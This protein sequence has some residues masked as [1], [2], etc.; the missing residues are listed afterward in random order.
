MSQQE[1]EPIYCTVQDVGD[2]MNIS[3][4]DTTR[5]SETQVKKKINEIQDSINRKT[6]TAF[7][8]VVA[9][10]EEHDLE[11]SYQQGWGYNISLLHRNVKPFDYSKGD[12]IQY[13]NGSAWIDIL[14]STLPDGIV[15]HANSGIISFKS[16]VYSFTTSRKFNIIYRYGEATVPKAIR[17]LTAKMVAI[18]FAKGA[19]FWGV[20]PASGDN[21][22]I[23]DAIR[24]WQEDIDKTIADYE[25]IVAIY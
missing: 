16:Y 7:S 25:E 6:K 1:S 15:L 5:P 22:R 20:L 11:G 21:S 19:I 12:R 24:L 14:T 10:T 8:E 3:I 17:L 23:S 18:E 9:E 2:L 4:S 13:W